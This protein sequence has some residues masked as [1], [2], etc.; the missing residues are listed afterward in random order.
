[1]WVHICVYVCWGVWECVYVWVCDM[2]G[3]VSRCVCGCVSLC[4]SVSVDVPSLGYK[5]FSTATVFYLLLLLQLWKR[6]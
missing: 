2:C 5:P 6:A 3:S 4:G 1:M